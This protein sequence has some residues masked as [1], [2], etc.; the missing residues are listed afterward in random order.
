MA[1]SW[2]AGSDRSAAASSAYTVGVAV[3]APA[4]GDGV[5]GD[6]AYASCSS[7]R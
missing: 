3:D 5:V 4:D 1:G 6:A 2:S 7:P